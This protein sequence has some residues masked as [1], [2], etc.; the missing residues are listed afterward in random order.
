MKPNLRVS[1]VLDAS[2]RFLELLYS[3]VYNKSAKVTARMD[4]ARVEIREQESRFCRTQV[5]L[6]F[7]IVKNWFMLSVSISSYGCTR[8]VWRAREKRNSSFLSVL[9]TSQV[10]P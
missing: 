7:G 10:Y 4:G 9:Q 3:N 1:S 2:E 6:V 5:P 8:E